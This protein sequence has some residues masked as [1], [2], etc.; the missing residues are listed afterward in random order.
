[1]SKRRLIALAGQP[2]SGKSTI[3][4]GLTGA[5]QHV[6]NYPGV[7]VDKKTGYVN[8]NTTRVELVDLPGTYSLTSYSMEEIAARDFILNENPSLIIDVVDASNLARHLYLSLQLLEMEKPL[9]LC[10]NMMDVARRRRISINA[11]ALSKELGTPVIKTTGTKK[12]GFSALTEL[13]NLPTNDNESHFSLDYGPLETAITSLETMLTEA[14]GIAPLPNRW[15]SLKLLEED[16]ACQE[17]VLKH[18]PQKTATAILAQTQKICLDFENQQEVS[19]QKHIAYVRHQKCNELVNRY[20]SFPLGK[21]NL[22][23][24]KLDAFICHRF[25]GPVILLAILFTLYQVAIVYGNSLAADIWPFWDWAQTTLAGFLPQA[26]FLHDPL[27]R[28]LGIW[29]MKSVTAVLNYLPIFFLLFSMVAILEDSGYMPRMAFILDRIFRQFGLHGQSTLPLVLGGVYVG[30]CAIPAVIAAK[31]IPDERARLA[32]ILITPMMNCLAKTPLYLVLIGAYFS[33]HAGLAMFFI[34]TVTLLMALPVAKLL[35]ITV[36]RR[37]PS[38]PF[39]MELPP[40]HLPSAK[41]V[42]FKAVERCWMFAKK[43]LTVVLAVAVILFVLIS[44]PG[45]DAKRDDH[46]AQRVGAAQQAFMKKLHTT[47]F[48]GTLTVEQLPD[49][50]N[51]DEEL[52]DAKRGVTVQ[53]EA[54]K[55]DARFEQKNPL[56]FSIIRG[57]TDDNKV[58]RAPLRKLINE[59][60]KIRRELREEVF[61]NSFLGKAGKA[62]EPI[63]QYAGFS[64][65]INIALLSAFAAK[66]NSAATLGAI[67]G[68]DGDSGT[69]QE[70]MKVMES[71]FTPLHALALMLFMA[72]YPPCVPA[73]VMVRMQAHSTGWMLF[74]ILYQSLLGVLVATL[75]F[76]G[77]SALGL[78]GWQAMWAFYGLCI[79]LTVILGFIPEK[80]VREQVQS[81]KLSV[82]SE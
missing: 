60:K 74:S 5:R 58:L 38:A 50:L 15:I 10:L 68:I 56:Y 9:A 47:S 44:F 11:D 66:E 21:T 27:L 76:T 14:G 6:A 81:H 67:Y 2:N 80:T 1:M 7:T 8:I 16:M 71:Q 73:S 77:G 75:V 20:V 45:L 12:Q 34:A 79:A 42:L 17:M 30:G 29:C 37:K 70:N 28:S 25:L 62:L 65:K 19:P 35:S 39:I 18:F 55:I 72:L 59:R 57:K 48:S 13:I 69:V 49:L 46:Y 36:L 43:V 23:T 22:L 61:E 82:A 24:D 63:T 26:G 32:T 3:F 54:N 4:N 53:E 51:F 31:A 41:F 40:Y 33:E 78:T 64:W 52:K